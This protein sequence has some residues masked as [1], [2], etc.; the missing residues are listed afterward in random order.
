MKIDKRFVDE[1]E[2][3]DAGRSIVDVIIYLAKQLSCRIVAEGV[4]IE[5][6]LRYLLDQDVDLIQG[7]FVAKPMSLETLLVWQHNI[8][9]HLPNSMD[10][11]RTLN[12]MLRRGT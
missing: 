1:L 6:Q 2:H 7:Y 8:G 4:E 11:D 9:Q 12:Q 10:F 5:S 3:S